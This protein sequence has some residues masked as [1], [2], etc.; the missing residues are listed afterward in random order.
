MFG[1]IMGWPR[2]DLKE[3][4]DVERG[5]GV[6]EVEKADWLRQVGGNKNPVAVF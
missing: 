3:T 1:I 5:V 6:G 2:D 4:N